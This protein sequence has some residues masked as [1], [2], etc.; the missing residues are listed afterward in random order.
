MPNKVKVKVFFF[1]K[2]KAKYNYILIK[3]FNENTY[4]T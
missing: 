1:E 4:E 2:A 3:A